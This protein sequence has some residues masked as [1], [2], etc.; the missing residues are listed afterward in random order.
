MTTHQTLRIRQHDRLPMFSAVVEDD[1]GRAVD[2]AGGAQ[3]YMILRTVDGSPVFGDNPY[4]LPL[5]GDG[6]YRAQVLILAP[7]EG[8]I[9]YDWLPEET[10]SLAPVL[11][12]VAV[13]VE[14]A[15]GRTLIAPT[16][17]ETQLSVRSGGP[18]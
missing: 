16:A 13:V 3:A 17:R 10:A 7:R 12:D 18:P 1:Q 15:D 4:N 11:F 2:L 9:V 5:T 14:W 6:S 8:I